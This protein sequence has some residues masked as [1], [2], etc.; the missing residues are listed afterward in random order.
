MPKQNSIYK[1]NGQ[2]EKLGKY[3]IGYLHI[4]F[5]VLLHLV[6]VG[7]YRWLFDAGFIM[8]PPQ[9]STELI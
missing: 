1:G 8:L 9:D 5:R 6:V 7:H 4:A 3:S 2:G